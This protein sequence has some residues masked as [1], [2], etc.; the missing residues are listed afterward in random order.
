MKTERQIDRCPALCPSGLKS[1]GRA[2]AATCFSLAVG[3]A[4]AS[5]QESAPEKAATPIA[6]P[7]D[8]EPTT[9]GVFSPGGHDVDQPIEIASDSLEVRQ[10]DQLAI[11]LG[12]VD[13][14]QGEMRL[15][16]DKLEVHYVSEDSETGPADSIS[17]MRAVGSVFVSSPNETAQGEWADY[18]VV[19][20]TLRI[21]DNVLLTQ[22]ENVLCG[23][24]LDMNLDTGI[25]ELKGGCMSG[26]TTASR[27]Q[28]VFYPSKSKAKESSE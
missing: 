27:V 6:K 26:G 11:F 1:L 18:D 13:A 4:A 22:G 14:I 28:G 19:T 8:K 15:K 10:E 7:T 21:H 23:Q 12:N 17:R 24:Q 20:R 25:S 2:A 9:G 3:L 16:T 5:A